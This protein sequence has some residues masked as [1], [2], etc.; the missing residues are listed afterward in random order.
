MF[1]IFPCLLL[2]Q[3]SLSIA[4]LSR[5]QL[6]YNALNALL[7]FLC[8]NLTFTTQTQTM[9]NSFIYEQFPYIISSLENKYNIR[10]IRLKAINSCK[11][12][13]VLWKL[14]F[15]VKECVEM[16]LSENF[17]GNNSVESHIMFSLFL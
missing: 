6:F 14:N 15:V 11:R 3:L 5:M 2:P 16:G 10:D 13:K 1:I 12:F 8:E 17:M 7:P 4:Y 9:V